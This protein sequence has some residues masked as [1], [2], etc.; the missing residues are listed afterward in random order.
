MLIDFLRTKT[1]G[2]NG[3]CGQQNSS[4]QQSL[5]LS[6][7]LR[8]VQGSPVE[9]WR[10]RGDVL[11]PR[12][13]GVQVEDE[14]AGGVEEER[15]HPH[16]EDVHE[17]PRQ[18]LQRVPME[19]SWGQVVN[20]QSQ[21]TA[22]EAYHV[23]DLEVTIGEGHGIGGGGHRE[24]EGIGGRDS[25]W[26]HEVE[27][28]DL[29]LHCLQGEVIE[30]EGGR[31]KLTSSASTGRKRVVVARLDMTSVTPAMM[32]LTQRAMAGVGRPLRD[33]S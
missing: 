15:D 28:V 13:E 14:S 25:G 4:T 16:T 23:V 20:E 12:G 33:S 24:H 31:E 21:A 3:T 6:H 27:R 30:R 22:R 32:T 29:Q 17:Q 11:G 19:R 5:G 18:H 26:D 7:K 1:A 2:D 9:T 10:R 8:G